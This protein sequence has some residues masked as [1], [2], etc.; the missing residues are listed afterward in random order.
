[1]VSNL[2]EAVMKR[3]GATAHPAKYF[4]NVCQRVLSANWGKGAKKSSSNVCV[5]TWAGGS[6]LTPTWRR[7]RERL[8]DGRNVLLHFPA[9]RRPHRFASVCSAAWGGQSFSSVVLVL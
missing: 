6:F 4:K 7:G 2:I 1:M 8:H 9:Q 3:R 5:R